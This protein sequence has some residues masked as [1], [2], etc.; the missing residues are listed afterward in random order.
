[1]RIFSSL[2]ILGSLFLS[3][4]L[5][6][7]NCPE[8]HIIN[9]KEYPV[10]Q[11]GRQC[12]FYLDD[13]GELLAELMRTAI[14]IPFK[15][16]DY[17]SPTYSIKDISLALD[18]FLIEDFK[19]DVRIH[20]DAVKENL[21]C[22]KLQFNFKLTAKVFLSGI[23]LGTF[24]SDVFLEINEL[25]AM[26]NYLTV[27]DELFQMELNLIEQIIEF[28]SYNVKFSDSFFNLIA[29]L[30]E[31]QVF[32]G[33]VK[34]AIENTLYEYQ[35]IYKVSDYV[36]KDDQVVTFNPI[37]NR[38]LG[39]AP[40]N[41]DATASSGL[42]VAF[43]SPS[44]KI[45]INGSSVTMLEA[46]SVTVFA[47]QAGNAQFNPASEVSHSF[48]IKPLKPTITLSGNHTETSVLTSSSANGNQWYLN[49]VAISGATNATYP[50]TEPGV[51]TVSVKVDDCTSDL[52]N[53]YSLIITGLE[54]L[55]DGFKL[56][57]NPVNDKVRL[58]LPNSSGDETSIV[59]Y[60]M[61]GRVKEKIKTTSQEIEI[62]VSEFAT[63]TYIFSIQHSDSIHHVKLLKK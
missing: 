49:G 52:S 17:V 18:A 36:I 34:P 21:F 31:Q 19:Y 50:A 61:Q 11:I 30:F 16:A 26:R 14:D 54:K 35:T 48:C 12:F 56:F 13:K 25:S 28:K 40:F 29:S 4:E 22:N 63:G 47:S 46:G 33:Y 39:D 6:G 1:M 15:I 42:P 23:S 53:G 37:Q 59:I 27:E 51:Y 32:N 55:N 9:E 24:K 44:S 20:S 2:T 7:Q 8:K 38:T 5:T 10:A 3:I 41:L 43:T 57:P 60:D 45:A 58:I 62:S